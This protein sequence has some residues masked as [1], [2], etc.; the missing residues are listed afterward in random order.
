MNGRRPITARAQLRVRAGCQM[1]AGP[2][3]LWPDK[4][5]RKHS[6]A[7]GLARAA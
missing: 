3:R 1:A 7:G 5:H 2:P 4:D 6:Y